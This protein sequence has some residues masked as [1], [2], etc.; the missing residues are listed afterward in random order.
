MVDSIT[1]AEGIFGNSITACGW[2]LINF[3]FSVKAN[4]KNQILFI[5]IPLWDDL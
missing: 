2:G 3:D 4:A 1:E 5:K